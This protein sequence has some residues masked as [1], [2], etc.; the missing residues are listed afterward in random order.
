M[1]WVTW[2]PETRPAYWRN[3]KTYYEVGLQLWQNTGK[4]LEGPWHQRIRTEVLSQVLHSSNQATAKK[5]TL[6][7][8]IHIFIFIYSFIFSFSWEQQQQYITVKRVNLYSHTQLSQYRCCQ[9]LKVFSWL[10]QLND[11]TRVV[12][13]KLVR[14]MTRHFTF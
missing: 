10:H 8:S 9:L 14:V 11:K 5:C 4:L 3:T 2:S 1:A 13:Q 12:N 7:I 6:F